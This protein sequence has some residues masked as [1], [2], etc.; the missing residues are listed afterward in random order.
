MAYEPRWERFEAV[1]RDGERR[2]VAF[3]RAG[4]LT[5][6]D[7]PELYFFR[8]AVARVDDKSEEIVVGIS[9]S[10]LKRFQ[11]GR[12]YL[13]REAKIDLAGL[14]LKKRIEAGLALESRNLFLR[15]EELAQLAGEL[16]IPV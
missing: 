13:S 14:L 7:Q 3:L 9:G 4:F 8:V 6:G 1:G 5:M 2:A 10:S 16:G 15:D 12:K 11:Q